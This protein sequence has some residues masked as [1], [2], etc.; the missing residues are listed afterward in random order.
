M[1]LYKKYTKHPKEDKYKLINRLTI[2]DETTE[3]EIINSKKIKKY[4]YWN[5]HFCPIYKITETTIQNPIFSFFETKP[6]YTLLKYKINKEYQ[7]FYKLK[8]IQ[9]II[10]SF[11]YLLDSLKIL[12]KYNILFLNFHY[13]NIRIHQN[14]HCIIQNLNNNPF[15]V[16]F[17][18]YES[19]KYIYYPFEYHV[20]RYLTEH[21]I[22][23]IHLDIIHIVWKEWISEMKTIIP[24]KY[25][26]DFSFHSLLH[27]TKQQLIHLLHENIHDWYLYGL[28]ILYFPFFYSMPSV[29]QLFLQYIKRDENVIDMKSR[30]EEIIYSYAELE[31]KEKYQTKIQIKFNKFI[32]F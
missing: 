19:S 24:E 4:T 3:T 12:K 30:F 29:I 26:Q 6:N 17:A 9:Q 1:I 31:W 7:D 16:N 32:F 8:N 25:L 23:F 20:L 14:N 15:S 22:D 27:L 10:F 11:L 13:Q 18:D 21:N 2:K 28:I 5:L